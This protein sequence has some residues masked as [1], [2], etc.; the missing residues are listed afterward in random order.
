MKSNQ[1]KIIN[2][3]LNIY[4]VMGISIIIIATILI[5]SPLY[6][7]VLFSVNNQALAQE[8]QNVE[9]L[10]ENIDNTKQ[11]NIQTPS[12][13]LPPIDSSLTKMNTLLIPSIGVVGKIH[14]NTNSTKG[15][16]NGVWR[17]GE[18]GDPIKNSNPI[19]LAS[20]RYGYLTWS[21]KYRKENSFLN[22]PKTKVG[23]R[24]EIIWQQRRFVYE[25]YKTQE[26]TKIT[27]YNAD[28][29]IYTC[30]TLNSDIRVFRYAKLVI[31]K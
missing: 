3:I 16:E 31:N 25:I 14:E 19:I 10:V 26:N 6:P 23:D 20:H 17:V 11:E 15:L 5:L 30:K 13:T 24:V 1:K 29:I 9:T 8:Q 7:Y 2:S 21:N 4:T 28:L 27:D 12:T 22:L 18:W